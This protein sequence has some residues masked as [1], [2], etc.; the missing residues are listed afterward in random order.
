MHSYHNNNSLISAGVGVRGFAYLI[1]LLIKWSFVGVARLFF[2]ISRLGSTFLGEP[3]LFSFS[4]LDIIAYFIGVSYFILLVYCS[5]V[6]VG[7][8]L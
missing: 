7:K 2:F 8:F 1:D 5:G 4:I 6:T 3:V